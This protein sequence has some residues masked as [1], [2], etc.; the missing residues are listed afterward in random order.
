MSETEAAKRLVT[1]TYQITFDFGSGRGIA[2]SGNFYA[3]DQIPDMN[4]NLDQVWHVLQRL[5]AKVQ[6]ETLELDL[7]QSLKM[8]RDT[9]E[10]VFR[11]ETEMESFLK[12][13]KLVPTQ[14]RADAE[15]M[16]TNIMKIKEQI[17]DIEALLAETKQ[18]AA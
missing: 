5:R 11:Q 3:D 8:L 6:V 12:H 13:G 18:R 14:K 17:A 10:S 1:R 2:V 9:E 7:K 16:K 15:N 4:A